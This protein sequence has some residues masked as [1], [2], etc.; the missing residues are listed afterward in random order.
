ME[1]L[2]RLGL[3]QPIPKLRRQ[4]DSLSGILRADDGWFILPMQHDY[5]RHWGAYTG[6]M[7]ERDWKQPERRIFDPTFRCLL[8][9]HYA[10]YTSDQE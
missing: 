3:I 9:R 10:F 2:A 1:L 4:I 6:L 8:I 7:L 5:F